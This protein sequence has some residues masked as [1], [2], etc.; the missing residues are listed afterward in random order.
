MNCRGLFFVAIDRRRMLAVT[1]LIFQLF[2]IFLAAKV[3]AELSE[4]AGQPAVLGELLAGVVIGPFAL[5]W[6]GVAPAAV[7]SEFHGDAAAAQEAVTLVHHVLAEIGV[8]VLLFFVGLETRIADI[9]Q[10]GLRA[11]LVAVLGVITPFVLGFVLVGPLLG[12]PQ[13]EAAFI[14]AAMVA[15]SVG[16]TARVLRDLGVLD[17][18]EAR[19]ILAAAVIDD[20]LA[21]VILAIV[22]GL[23]TTGRADPITIA[24]IAGQAVV[25]TGFAAL[26]GTGMVRRYGLHLERLRMDGAP[27][28]VALLVMLGMASLAAGIGLAA[29]IGAFLAGMVFAEAREHFEL[30][31]QTLPIYQ[32]LAP[33]FFVITGTQVDWRLFTDPAIMGLAGAVTLV[34]VAGKLVGCG[35]GALGMG[36]RAVAIIGAG[37]VPRGE[38]GLIVASLGLSLGAITGQ[39]FGVVVVM[40]LLTTV[41]VPPV[42]HRLYRAV[43]AEAAGED[44]QGAG[45]LPDM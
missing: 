2:L 27:L 26:V 10:V 19:V 14:G 25:F 9:W 43:P 34:A 44:G 16:I 23:A 8:I 22:T 37:M 3:A 33:F 5:G 1:Q 17:S 45:R 18:V 21:M 12:Y 13:L 38:V 11:V 15:T 36:R 35:L 42:L 4:R 28:A 20:I 29:I 40:S 39:V 32:F 30:E 7:V 24:L 31:Q 41:M 6:V